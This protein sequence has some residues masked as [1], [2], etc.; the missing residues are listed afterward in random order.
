MLAVIKGC[1]QVFLWMKLLTHCT[2][3][4]ILLVL[5]A[6][7]LALSCSKEGANPEIVI[8]SPTNNAVGKDGGTVT[9]SF[10]SAIEWTATSSATWCTLSASKG[11]GGNSLSIK[12]TCA[13]NETYDSRTATVTIKS[14]GTVAKNITIEQDAKDGL[15]ISSNRM[16]LNNDAQQITITLQ[17]N[18]EYTYTING[19]WI[20]PV[21][22]SS[23]ETKAL[24][25]ET[26][27]FN[28]AENTTYDNREG[29]ITFKSAK[30]DLSSTVTIYQSQVNA[31]IISK[32][33]VAID[34][35]EQVLNVAIKTNVDFEV[36]IPEDAKSWIS[37]ASTKALV[38]KTVTLSIKE[39]ELADERKA[40]ITIKDSKT[41]ASDILNITQNGRDGVIILGEKMAEVEASAGSQEITVFHSEAIAAECEETWVTVSVVESPNESTTKYKITW[42]ANNESLE[43]E[44][45]ILFKE[46]KPEGRSD[47]FTLKQK[48]AKGFL[49]AT[50]PGLYNLESEEAEYAYSKYEHLLVIAPAVSAAKGYFRLVQNKENA[51]L[52]VENIPD[53]ARLAAESTVELQIVQNITT[54]MQYSHKRVFTVAK[55]SE[56]LV[57]LKS[58]SDNIGLVIQMK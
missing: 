21:T 10:S 47:T 45:K 6:L 27:K 32:K 58:E 34:A 33:D 30:G 13:K 42:V 17:K 46:T 29:S 14:G 9:L 31:I 8:S 52:S 55:I 24:S 26:L 5:T 18:V 20:T 53:M 54:R 12:V 39:N 36:S 37:V 56:N 15:I 23:V 51:F 16:D 38:D 11:D 49:S 25:N 41:Q 43:R 2:M 1:L 28:V 19:E 40:S 48:G 7:M 3:K 44:A 50:T 35:T 22:A 4:R 57:W